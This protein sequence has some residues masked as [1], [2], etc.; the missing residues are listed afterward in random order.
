MLRLSTLSLIL[1]CAACEERATAEQCE[2]LLDRYTELLAASEG[3][4]TSAEE[5]LRLQREARLR[6]AADPEFSRCTEEVSKREIECAM[7]A[8]TADEIERCLL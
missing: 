1:A 5:L 2:A 3:R 4:Q 7:R 8:P 6:A